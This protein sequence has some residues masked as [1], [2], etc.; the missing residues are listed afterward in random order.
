VRIFGQASQGYGL[1]TLQKGNLRL[2]GLLA[3]AFSDHLVG[4]T[5]DMVK[6]SR[7]RCF[8]ASGLRLR[9]EMKPEDTH[10]P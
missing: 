2:K 9:R 5:F 8:V 1:R 4:N 6:I 10:A 7:M 3:G